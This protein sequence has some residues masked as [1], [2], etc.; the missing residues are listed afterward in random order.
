MSVE[1]IVCECGDTLE[2][3]EIT[4]ALKVKCPCGC[5]EFK[6]SEAGCFGD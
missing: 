5:Q 1:L 6:R 3:H 4:A 2:D